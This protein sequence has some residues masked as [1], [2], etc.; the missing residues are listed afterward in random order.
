MT[1][2]KCLPQS[3]F[4]KTNKMAS[5]ENRLLTAVQNGGRPNGEQ[6]PDLRSAAF[7]P[8]QCGLANTR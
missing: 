3:F 2:A 8:L 7:M 1:F 5:S 4:E 6:C